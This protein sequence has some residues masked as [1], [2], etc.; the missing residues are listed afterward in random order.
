M[1]LTLFFLFSATIKAD[2]FR[3]DEPKGMSIWSNEGHK[4]TPD[5]FA[6]VNPI[7]ITDQKEMTIIWG[8][9]KSVAG[10]EEKV[11]KAIIINRS[12]ESISGIALDEGVGGS[13][14][15][16]YTIDIKR[17]FL[18]MSS[19]KHNEILNHSIANTFVSKC[20]K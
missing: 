14:T 13:A 7:V 2:V 10:G 6:G 4:I 1:L 15:I 17:G 12:P 9:S 20:K 5:G 19:H 11:W 16:L 8:D 18:Y 3:C